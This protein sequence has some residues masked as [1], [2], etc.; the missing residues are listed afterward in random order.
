MFSAGLHTGIN[1]YLNR[2]FSLFLQGSYSQS[3]NSVINGENFFKPY[4]IR[5]GG[6]ITYRFNTLRP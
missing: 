4:F 2:H 1:F 6:G 3:L 5:A